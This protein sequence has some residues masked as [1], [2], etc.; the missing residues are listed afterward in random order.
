MGLTLEIW[1][2]SWIGSPR[3]CWG[4]RRNCGG[5]RGVRGSNMNPLPEFWGGQAF[6]TDKINKF[7]EFFGNAE[8]TKKWKRFGSYEKMFSKFT[9]HQ[10]EIRT[11]V[12]Y[13]DHTDWSSRLIFSFCMLLIK[14][15]VVACNNWSCT[16]C[17]EVLWAVVLSTDFSKLH[18]DI[19]DC[20]NY[21]AQL[22]WYLE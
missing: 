12:Q 2:E 13:V 5:P 17:C 1:R 21:I 9:G 19:V 4:S 18:K 3:F 7:E 8:K 22:N 10:S 16:Y 11:H 15:N 6:R 14:S 20:K